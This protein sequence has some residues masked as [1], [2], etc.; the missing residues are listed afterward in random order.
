[1]T[2]EFEWCQANITAPQADTAI[3]V[4][5]GPSFDPAS[6]PELLKMGDVYAINR[7]IRSFT[8]QKPKAVFLLDKFECFPEEAEQLKDA[9]LKKIVSVQYGE[10]WRDVPNVE[11]LRLNIKK[12]RKY[13]PLIYREYTGPFLTTLVAW[14]YLAVAGY[15]RIGLVGVDCRF[16][17]TPYHFDFKQTLWQLKRK[18]MQYRKVYHYLKEWNGYGKKRGITTFNLSPLSALSKCLPTEQIGVT[19]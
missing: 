4:A 17:E 10:T 12:E 14:W 7:A 15:K 16:D 2:R 9:R 8:G 3:L 13:D 11:Q 18:R 5:P 6:V 19:V 1:M